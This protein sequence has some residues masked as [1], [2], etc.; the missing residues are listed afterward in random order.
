MNRKVL[1]SMI[2]LLWLFFVTFAIL[3][4]FFGQEFVAVMNNSK[5]VEIGNFIDNHNWATILSDTLVS[6]LIMHFYLCACKRVWN[7]NIKNYIYLII[8][9][10]ALVLIYRENSALGMIVDT[11]MMIA[12]PIH[13]KCSIGHYLSVFLLHEAG[14]LFTLFVR[15]EPIYL[16]STDYATQF[17]L[18]FD[19]Y[20]WL[21][22]YY[23]Y[24]NM[25]KEESIWA[26]LL[27]PFSVIREKLNTKRKL[28]DCRRKLRRKEG[29]V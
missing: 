26:N 17:I 16:A 11:T 24:S 28:K 13:L 12:I 1:W 15:S 23:L 29:R 10:F 25:Y 3:K 21:V 22:L 2:V 18:L 6:S 9:V 27:F 5:I 19:V 4:L 14:Q 20:V 7:L 8:Y